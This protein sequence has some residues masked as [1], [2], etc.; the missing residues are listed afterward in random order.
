MKKYKHNRIV[1]ISRMIEIE[2]NIEIIAPLRLTKEEREYL[3]FAIKMP[4]SEITAFIEFYDNSSPKYDEL[5]FVSMLETRYDENRENIIKRIQ[6]VRRI[7]KYQKE[8]EESKN[9]S[10]VLKKGE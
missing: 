6:Q 9:F 7:M 1:E 3:E 5:K 4:I 2:E 10:K 8:K